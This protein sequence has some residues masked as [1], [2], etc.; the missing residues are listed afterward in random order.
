MET[1]RTCIDCAC[2][3][4]NE[5]NIGCP[6]VQYNTSSNQLKI[7]GNGNT[8]NM[9]SDAS[10]NLIA[11]LAIMPTRSYTW[12]AEG[13][14]TSILT[15]Y[16][17]SVIATYSYNALGQRV[18]AS[19]T[20]VG[21]YPVVQDYDAFGNLGYHGDLTTW[22]YVPF[23][24]VGGKV[25]GSMTA[26]RSSSTA[27]H[28]ARRERPRGR[29]GR[30]IAARFLIPGASAGG[31]RARST[32]SALPASITCETRKAASTK[33]PTACSPPATVAGSAPTRWAAISPIRSR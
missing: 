2:R 21:A 31:L 32:T 1:C 22:S 25:Y 27:T 15:P 26:V 10:G 7:V 14:L 18:Q 29:T 3:L 28:W 20:G 9:G 19:G 4:D 11:D 30:G 17:G 33:P 8:Q 13:R 23:P 16:L 12:D 5:R 24:P 6:V